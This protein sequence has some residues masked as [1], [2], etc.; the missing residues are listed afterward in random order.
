MED[1][2]R[3]KANNDFWKDYL[4]YVSVSTYENC[5]I[6]FSKEELFKRGTI[7]KYFLA[8]I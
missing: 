5:Y 2:G 8:G 6:N 3:Q 7:K 1:K 4:Y